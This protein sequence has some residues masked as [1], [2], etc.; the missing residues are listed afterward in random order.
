VQ[1]VRDKLAVTPEFKPEVGHVQR[2]LIRKGVTIQEGVIGPQTFNGAFFPGGANQIQ[3]L[4]F[5]DRAKLIP[6]GPKRPIK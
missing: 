4:N 6:L 2:F 1:F 5:A 3:I